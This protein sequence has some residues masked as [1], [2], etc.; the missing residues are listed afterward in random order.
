MFLVFSLVIHFP[1]WWLSSKDCKCFHF[2]CCSSTFSQGAGKKSVMKS[3]AGSFSTEGYG[4]KSVNANEWFDYRSC[5]ERHY[6]P[7]YT[8]QKEKSWG[9]DDHLNPF[10]VALPHFTRRVTCYEFQRF[11][12]H[13]WRST[14]PMRGSRAIPL[15]FCRS[16]CRTV[17][18]VS[19]LW[20]QANIL[21]VTRS[22]K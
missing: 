15:G 22:I 1:L 16:K 3:P 20:L 18:H 13:K 4:E 5:L 6:S 10:T 2:H 7:N 21:S 17:T 8:A 12:L 19:P 11:K 9:P 14:H